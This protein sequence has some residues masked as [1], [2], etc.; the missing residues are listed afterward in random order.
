VIPTNGKSYPLLA[1]ISVG[2]AATAIGYV[3]TDRRA[4]AA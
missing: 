2:Y 1:C 3:A 4:T